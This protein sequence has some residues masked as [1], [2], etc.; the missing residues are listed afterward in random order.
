[1]F[2]L[3]FVI[4]LFNLLDDHTKYLIK[5]LAGNW[6]DNWDDPLADWL[7]TPRVTNQY[8]EL[9]FTGLRFSITGNIGNYSAK[10]RFQVICG[11]AK[12]IEYNITVTS[13]ID[14]IALKPFE[15]SQII[16]SY[17]NLYDFITF[18]RVVDND[19]QPMQGKIIDKVRV[20]ID[21]YIF[22]SSMP[23]TYLL[24]KMLLFWKLQIWELTK[25]EFYQ[26]M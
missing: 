23:V 11:N 6:S 25:T 24:L 3:N 5:P 8:G 18:L 16:I 2:S 1:M 9:S 20:S 12:S 15:S 7:V 14:N 22:S 10:Y 21:K 13:R 17:S 4:F 19:Q 26:C